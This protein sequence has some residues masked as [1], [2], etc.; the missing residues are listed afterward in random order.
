M[1]Q[2]YVLSTHNGTTDLP[3]GEVGG[4]YSCKDETDMAFKNNQIDFKVDSSF[5]DLKVEP[6]VEKKEGN[7][8]GNSEYQ[9]N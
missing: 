5:V 4:S 7:D 8:F 9:S 2:T 1:N 3:N 6:F